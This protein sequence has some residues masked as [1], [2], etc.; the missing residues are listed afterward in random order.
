MPCFSIFVLYPSHQS[1]VVNTLNHIY[2]ERHAH[3]LN[4]DIIKLDAFSGNSVYEVKICDE[5]AVVFLRDLIAPFFVAYIRY[6]Y[7]L[8]MLYKNSRIQRPYISPPRY[9]KLL[10]DIYWNAVHCER[11]NLK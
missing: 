11:N 6:T 3:E 10:K 2:I 9:N 7:S 1:K 8:K 4:G 5:N